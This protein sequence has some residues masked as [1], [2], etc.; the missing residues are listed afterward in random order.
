MKRRENLFLRFLYLSAWR[1]HIEDGAIKSIEAK[2]NV[3]SKTEYK[4]LEKRLK[5]T[6]RVLGKKTLEYEIL[7]EAVEIAQK[8][9]LISG[10]PLPGRENFP[11][12]Q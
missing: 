6:E 2:E 4:V 10:Q 8:K 12:V 9:K 11:S 7:R 5:E 3:V 1:K